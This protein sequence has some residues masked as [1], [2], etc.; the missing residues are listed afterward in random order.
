MRTAMTAAAGA[1]I[2]LGQVFGAG[3]AL[4]EH[5]RHRPQRPAAAAGGQPVP[6]QR[7]LTRRGTWDGPAL[8]A[9][10][11]NARSASVHAWEARVFIT[12]SVFR[13]LVAFG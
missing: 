10:D 4:A 8:T 2:A 3:A 11:R 12:A 9:F 1:A 7:D 6:A 13:N 5:P